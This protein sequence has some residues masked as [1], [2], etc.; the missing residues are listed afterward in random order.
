MYMLKVNIVVDEVAG[1]EDDLVCSGKDGP[2]PRNRQMFLRA[3]YVVMISVVVVSLLLLRTYPRNELLRRDLRSMDSTR[4]DIPDFQ[5]VPVFFIN[6]ESSVDRRRFM[7]HELSR[8]NMNFKRVQ[9][10]TVAEAALV[11]MD[12]QLVIPPIPQEIA[13]ISSH[14]LAMWEAVTDSTLNPFSKYAIIME[15]DVAFQFDINFAEL[16]ASAPKDF[17]ILQ[18]TTSNSYEVGKM[19]GEYVVAVETA[20]ELLSLSL[21]RS[22]HITAGLWSTQAYIINKAAVQAFVERSVKIEAADRK[23][24]RLKPA[25]KNHCQSVS[26]AAG[27]GAVSLV[28]RNGVCLQPFRMVADL[29]LYA[30]FAPVYTIRVPIFNGASV[31]KV[32]TIP[33]RNKDK[34][35]TAAIS[36][37]EIGKTI[38]RAKEASH[39]LPSFISI[40]SLAEIDR[41]PVRASQNTSQTLPQD[42]SPCLTPNCSTVLP[43]LSPIRP[44]SAAGTVSTLPHRPSQTL[45][46][47]AYSRP[48]VASPHSRVQVVPSRVYEQPSKRSSGAT[49][50]SGSSFQSAQTLQSPRGPPPAVSVPRRYEFRSPGFTVNQPSPPISSVTPPRPQRYDPVYSTTGYKP[51]VRGEPASTLRRYDPAA[52][53]SF[54]R[55]TAFTGSLG[56]TQPHLRPLNGRTTG[57]QRGIGGKVVRT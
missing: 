31:G 30:A 56:V 17:S 3:V 1:I 19:W 38:T 15:D 48:A 25:G 36:F 4:S 47:V 41:A 20:P 9:A 11:Q 49:R 33:T 44:A 6:L 8:R 46:S 42:S 37:N 53:T 27:N 39:L 26:S 21:W 51:S 24:I 18:L 12:V 50:S 5:S 23:T 34:D 40:S 55:P 10:V 29:Y 32:S 2:S 54:T 43:T 57:F 7:E 28:R 22:H 16:I 45:K 35:L 13:C 52:A 14:L